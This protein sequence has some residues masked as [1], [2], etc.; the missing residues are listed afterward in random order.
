MQGTGTRSFEVLAE[1]EPWKLF[2]LGDHGALCSWI[3]P[4][5]PKSG[6]RNW[7]DTTRCATAN[8]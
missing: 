4:L 1:T 6:L 5:D 7:L 2:G 3:N 8:A